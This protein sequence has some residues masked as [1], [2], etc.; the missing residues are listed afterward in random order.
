MYEY[1]ARSLQKPVTGHTFITEY[2]ITTYCRIGYRKELHESVNG[3]MKHREI[4]STIHTKHYTVN[5]TNY[6]K[7]IQ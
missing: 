7:L 1:L 6:L 3:K 5:Q 2:T 4:F